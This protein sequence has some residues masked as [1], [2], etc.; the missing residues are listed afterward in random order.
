LFVDLLR[1][2]GNLEAKDAGGVDQAIGVVAQP[3]DVAGIG[4]FAF[5]HR[6]GIVQ[7]MRQYVQLCVAPGDQC[8]I[9]P[10]P[11]VPVVERN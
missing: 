6:A 8:A 10:D 9:P 7:P 1:R 5:E 3:E 4:P 2:I 11:P